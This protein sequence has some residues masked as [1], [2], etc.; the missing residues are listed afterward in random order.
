MYTSQHSL[1]LFYNE[2]TRPSRPDN[3]NTRVAIEGGRWKEKES[4]WITKRKSDGSSDQKGLYT[5][6]RDGG[7]KAIRS[8][9]FGHCLNELSLSLSPWKHDLLKIR[10]AACART[11]KGNKDQRKL[12]KTK[13]KR[14]N[15]NEKIAG[16]RSIGIVWLRFVTNGR[17]VE[18][19][20]HKGGRLRTRAC[21]LNTWS[22]YA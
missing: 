15:K 13:L 11:W 7:F 22:C 3:N 5:T 9:F 1:G 12:N 17:P 20:E 10:L 16:S 14:I 2:V 4:S 19:R 21:W 18:R 6:I 8:V